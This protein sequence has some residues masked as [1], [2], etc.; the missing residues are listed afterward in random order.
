MRLC[1][2]VSKYPIY[3]LYMSKYGIYLCKEAI[4]MHHTKLALIEYKLL[5]GVYY[6]VAKWKT[7]R[8]YAVYYVD[9]YHLAHNFVLNKVLTR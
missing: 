8:F 6:F 2:D 4:V 9:S 1:G 7:L 5:Q 3:N